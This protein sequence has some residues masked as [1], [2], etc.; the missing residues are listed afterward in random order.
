VKNRRG[1]GKKGGGK[2]RKHDADDDLRER[3]RPARES[4]EEGEWSDG[5]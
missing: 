2:R 3:K 4:R 1:R 5:D